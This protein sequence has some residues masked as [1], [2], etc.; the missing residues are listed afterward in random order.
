MQSGRSMG[1]SG[2]CSLP[3]RLDDAAPEIC[4]GFR[5]LFVEICGGIR[6]L[7]SGGHG[8]GVVSVWPCGCVV[9]LRVVT[10]G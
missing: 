10:A 2:W 6:L 9:P 7:V 4:G 5:F 8:G 1:S 3:S